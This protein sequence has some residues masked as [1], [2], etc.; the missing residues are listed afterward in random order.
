MDADGRVVDSRMIVLILT[1]PSCG[2]S[3]GSHRLP[4][5]RVRI[6]FKDALRKF[7]ATVNDYV[8]VFAKDDEMGGGDDELIEIPKS[9][10]VA[11]VA[12][13]HVSNWV[14]IHMEE[15]SLFERPILSWMRQYWNSRDVAWM[16]NICRPFGFSP[17]REEDLSTLKRRHPVVLTWEGLA[18]LREVH[19]AADYLGIQVL[20]EGIDFFLEVCRKHT[21][22]DRFN[23]TLNINDYPKDSSPATGC[24]VV[25]NYAGQPVFLRVPAIVQMNLGH[26]MPPSIAKSDLMMVTLSQ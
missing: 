4:T 21:P 14:D 15:P 10:S 13:K 3:T 16:L 7:S 5:R 8:A 17:I 24:S 18:R 9:I 11:P 19:T 20:V 6:F 25:L 2:S 1:V 22:M 23:W 12:F 26:N